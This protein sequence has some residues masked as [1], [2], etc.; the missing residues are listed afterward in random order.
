MTE[1]KDD[2]AAALDQLNSIEPR[3]LPPL[4]PDQLLKEA[5]RGGQMPSAKLAG[6]FEAKYK[7][8]CVDDEEQVKEL[9]EINNHIL[10][11]G[12]LPAREEWVHAK[13]G[14]SYVVLKYLVPKEKAKKKAKESGRRSKESNSRT[15]RKK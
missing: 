3:D 2:F 6:Q 15:P 11:D 1:P 8:L 7:K 10:N 4:H 5:G 9:E 13:S 12:W 14:V